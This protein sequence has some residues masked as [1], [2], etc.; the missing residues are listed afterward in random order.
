M[1]TENWNQITKTY[2]TEED[3]HKFDIVIS[4]ILT[5]VMKCA[6]ELG[7]IRLVEFDRKNKE[8]LL[9]LRV[10]LMARDLYQIPVQID[11]NWWNRLIINWKIR[12]IFDKVDQTPEYVINGVWVQETLDWLHVK[13]DYT[14]D[15]SDVY[16]TYYEGSCG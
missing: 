10:A 16:E 6:E 12:K 14:F 3:F 4:E 1:N 7:V 13:L 11:C 8:H 9:V 15:F 2:P 5:E